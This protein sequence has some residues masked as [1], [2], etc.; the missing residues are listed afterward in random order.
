MSE[1]LVRMC[2]TIQH[3]FGTDSVDISFLKNYFHLNEMLNIMFESQG[4]GKQNGFQNCVL[5]KQ[6]QK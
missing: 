2:E 1:A 5:A 3:S 6:S 4:E